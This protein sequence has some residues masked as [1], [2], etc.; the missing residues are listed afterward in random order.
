[1]ATSDDE[2]AR[3]WASLTEEQRDELRM[4]ME[5]R[6]RSKLT[7]PR[8]TRL[9]GAVLG[10]ILPDGLVDLSKLGDGGREQEF[11]EGFAEGRLARDLGT[12]LTSARKPK[13]DET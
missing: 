1:M 2:D 4:A 11:K 6:V 3:A 8:F 7:K 9:V 13:K 10:S 5:D 12:L